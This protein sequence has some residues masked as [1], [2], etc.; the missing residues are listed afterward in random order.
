M[1]LWLASLETRY[2]IFL[3][4]VEYFEMFCN[5]TQTPN[6]FPSGSEFERLS[7]PTSFLLKSPNPVSKCRSGCHVCKTRRYSGFLAPN[8]QYPKS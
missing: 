8:D 6:V 1:E 2:R 7:I 3:E 5:D 4:I